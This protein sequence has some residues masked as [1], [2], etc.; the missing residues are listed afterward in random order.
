MEFGFGNPGCLY[1]LPN[2]DGYHSSRRPVA[3]I[4]HRGSGCLYSNMRGGCHVSDPDFWKT[5]GDL[6][7]WALHTVPRAT[8]WQKSVGVGNT[9]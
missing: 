4:G 5:E 1:A 2:N 6:V 9:F 3:V 8:R 7:G